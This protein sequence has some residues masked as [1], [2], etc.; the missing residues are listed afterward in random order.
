M[1]RDGVIH[2]GHEE[3]AVQPRKGKHIQD[4]MSHFGLLENA[5]VVL[6]NV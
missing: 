4:S 2:D 3:S 1:A 5:W 6:A